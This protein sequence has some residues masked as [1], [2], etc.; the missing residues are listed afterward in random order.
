MIGGQDESADES[1][2]DGD[3]GVGVK[4]AGIA[5]YSAICRSIC[6]LPL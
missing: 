6:T 5:H 4:G 1:G 3:V 2:G